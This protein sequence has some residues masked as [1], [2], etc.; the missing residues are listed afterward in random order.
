MK[1]TRSKHWQHAIRGR[2]IFNSFDL[3]WA[4]VHLLW[5]TKSR[6]WLAHALCPHVFTLSKVVSIFSTELHWQSSLRPLLWVAG[7]HGRLNKLTVSLSRRLTYG[8][9][10]FASHYFLFSPAPNQ[11]TNSHPRTNRFCWL[12]SHTLSLAVRSVNSSWIGCRTQTRA[13][14]CLILTVTAI[15]H[16]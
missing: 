16:H 1:S 4:C 14:G 8:T 10:K 12:N 2:G 7:Y 13:Y 15:R 9:S 6:D 3:L 11:D 5:R